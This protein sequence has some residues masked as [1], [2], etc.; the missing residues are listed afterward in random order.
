MK[1]IFFSR[2]KILF[3]FFVILFLEIL[4]FF[5]W[6]LPDLK[7]IIFFSIVLITFLL[8]WHNINYGLLIASGELLIGS[9]GYLFNSDLF[10]Q[11]VSWRMFIWLIILI[12]WLKKLLFDYQKTVSFYKKNQIIVLGIFVLFIFLIIGI[13]KGFFNNNPIDVLLD[14]NAWFYLFLLL[15]WLM[16]DKKYFSDLWQL[17]LAAT[18]W[19]FVKTSL[20]LYFFSHNFLFIN[21]NLYGWTRDFRLGEITYAGGNFWRVFLQSQIFSLFITL[22]L[23]YLFWYWY[24]EKKDKKLFLFLILFSVLGLSVVLMSYSRSFWLGLL[25]GLLFCLLFIFYKKISWKN[26]F[27]FNLYLLI[28]FVLSFVFI[29]SIVKFP[30]PQVDSSQTSLFISRLQNPTSEA[31]GN[32]RLNQLKPLFGEIR[33]APLLGHGF[34]TKVS[35]NSTDPRILALG[36]EYAANYSTYA[37]E[38]GY[39]DI[40]LKIGL[41]GL[42]S[43]LFLIYLVIKKAVLVSEPLAIAFI[44]GFMAILITNLT[45]PYLNHPLGMGVI[46]WLIAISNQ[47]DPT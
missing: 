11:T 19:L 30:W 22:V 10:G 28:I 27:G 41:F 17:I 43:Y 18:T 31:A 29:F 37:F 38:L 7:L 13:G 5:T 32:S 25:G 15:P 6:Q 3:Y 8:T 21:S 40:W 45:T 23:I 14:V 46:F 47:N 44:F 33:Q 42:L 36:E 24:K 20:L 35:Y 39:L 4:S 1:E 12:V 16:F 9:F 34:G 2:D 26:F